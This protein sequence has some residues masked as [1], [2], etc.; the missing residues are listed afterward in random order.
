ELLVD[1][2]RPD[3]AEVA[4]RV[5]AALDKA[6][7]PVSYAALAPTE[8]ARRVAAGQ[9]DLYIGQLVAPPGDAAALASAF[10]A[11]GEAPGDLAAF[12][13]PRPI[14]PLFYRSLRA[15]HT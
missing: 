5:V 1:R 10:A 7:V 15:S 2:S 6:G 11:A 4:A 12:A 14:V 13:S 8:F 3:D 9:C